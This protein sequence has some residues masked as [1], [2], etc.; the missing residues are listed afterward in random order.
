MLNARG[1]SCLFVVAFYL[2]VS[3]EVT[4][5]VSC[6]VRSLQE[7]VCPPRPCL[8]E[9]REGP[10]GCHTPKQRLSDPE[11]SR[12]SSPWSGGDQSDFD[13]ERE[14]GT[15]HNFG[16][17]CSSS[18][19]ESSGES[20]NWAGAIPL[21][22]LA[23]LSGLVSLRLNLSLAGVCA[24]VPSNETLT[25]G[26]CDEESGRSARDS[27]CDNRISPL[28][29][30]S[31]QGLRG[32]S[33]MA[34]VLRCMRRIAR[35]LVE[36]IHS[37][38]PSP[39]YRQACRLFRDEMM[40]MGYD[41]AVVGAVLKALAETTGKIRDPARQQQEED[42]DSGSSLPDAPRSTRDVPSSTIP[43]HART[44]N[45]EGERDDVG[46]LMEVGMAF[47]QDTSVAAVEDS[48]GSGSIREDAL[49]I[50]VFSLEVSECTPQ[51]KHRYSHHLR[52]FSELHG[53]RDPGFL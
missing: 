23:L 34:R 49:F 26:A 36:R 33:R 51:G 24:R 40:A 27:V 18:D 42:E 44:P 1:H 20:N 47:V 39:G 41:E 15:E 35:Q 46:E 3:N 16:G 6:L 22:R 38:G 50:D 53:S 12:L 52:L 43:L 5:A 37:V 45:M 31:Q 19:Q 10:T 29:T 32:N 7:S 21:P 17:G 8:R 13:S 9:Q 30:I 25:A 11:S 4:A 2:Q 28:L 14:H 48:N